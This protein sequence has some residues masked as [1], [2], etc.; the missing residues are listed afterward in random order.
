MIAPMPRGWIEQAASDLR[1]VADIMVLSAD[2]GDWSSA[3]P[4]RLSAIGRLLQ[5][6]HGFLALMVY[7][8]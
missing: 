2:K 7:S 6:R 3:V 4:V 8:Q 1:L 5:R